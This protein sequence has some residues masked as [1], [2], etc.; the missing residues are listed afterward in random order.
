MATADTPLHLLFL[1]TGNSARSILGEAIANHLGNGR[2]R[3]WSAG[4]RPAGRV[5][6]QALAE[7]ARRGIPAGQ[8]CSKSWDVLATGYAPRFDLVITVCDSAA[9]EACPVLFG[10]FAKAHW[11]LPDPAGQTG[12]ADALAAAFRHTADVLQARLQALL[13]LPLGALSRAQ[14][15]DALCRIEAAHPARPSPVTA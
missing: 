10:D 12:D 3:A 13:A 14:L 5:H 9:N 2:I 4:S 1:C 15:V 7:L 8:A 11:G 6:P